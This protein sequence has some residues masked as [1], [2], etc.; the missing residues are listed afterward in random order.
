MRKLIVIPAYNE[1]ES[2]APLIRKL[3]AEGYKDILVIND[4]S[5]DNTEQIVRQSDVSLISLPINLGIGGAVQTGFRYAFENRYD[6]VL[7][8]D[9]DG[10]HDPSYIDALIRPILQDQADVVIGSRF[11]RK[12]GFQ[13]SFHRRMGIR[14]L[15]FLNYLL[16]GQHITDSTSGFR[17]Y[18]FKA[19]E[20]LADHYSVDFPEPEAIVS[21][22]KKKFRIVEVP[23]I[24]K[25]REKGRS[26]ISGLKSAY[27]IC[28]VIVSIIIE[29][30]RSSNE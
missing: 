9:G 15:Q 19:V 20:F 29:Y 21:L 16:T 22:L 3:K 14:V 26:S 2:I 5:T 7:Q 25:H 18:N 4:A 23:V 27:Y 28:K 17:A 1:E 12:M 11:I 13:S 24:M 30:G 8:V 6:I 10:Q